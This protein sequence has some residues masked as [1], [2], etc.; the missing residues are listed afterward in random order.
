MS[1]NPIRPPL[2]PRE[3]F[4]DV[5]NMLAIPLG[6]KLQLITQRVA[7]RPADLTLQQWRFMLCL[8]RNGDLHLRRLTRMAALDPAHASRA[9][10]QLVKR[11]FVSARKNP[12]DNRQRV[13]SLTPGGRDMVRAVWPRSKAP[14]MEIRGLYTDAEFALFKEFMARAIS[15]AEE[16]LDAPAPVRGAD[17]LPCD[18][19]DA[20]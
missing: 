12:D 2:L 13:F 8:A 4:D 5:L 7:L 6:M 9:A 10:T 15:H 18:A 19:D 16:I 3:E 14:S 20:A 11:G 1:K 17:T